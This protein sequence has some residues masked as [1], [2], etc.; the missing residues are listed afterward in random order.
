M[1]VA[2]FLVSFSTP[3]DL[4][5]WAEFILLKTEVIELLLHQALTAF[6]S[7]SQHP[8]TSTDGSWLTL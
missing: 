6:G 5:L 8:G 1:S 2:N 4:A 3:V 7:S